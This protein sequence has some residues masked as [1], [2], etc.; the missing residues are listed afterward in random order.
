MA[1]VQKVLMKVLRSRLAHDVGAMGWN[2]MC[3]LIGLKAIWVSTVYALC[4]GLRDSEFAFDTDFK[5]RV[6][7]GKEGIVTPEYESWVRTRVND[8]LP[9]PNEGQYMLMEDYLRV[10]LSEADLLR[11]ELAEAQADI[12]KMSV[13]HTRELFL[14]KVEVDS[15]HEKMNKQ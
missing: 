12:E 10:F 9:L 11:S 3:S 4:G 15:M 14:A 13:K 7:G 6:A 2:R 8:T 1:E 5:K